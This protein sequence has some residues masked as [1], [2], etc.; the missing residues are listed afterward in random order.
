MPLVNVYLVCA[1][2]S[3][4]SPSDEFDQ[5]ND[6]DCEPATSN[7]T[8]AANVPAHSQPGINC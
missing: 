2:P 8:T 1:A 6:T 4:Q 5:F 3:S 7:Y